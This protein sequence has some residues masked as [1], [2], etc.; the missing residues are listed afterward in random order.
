MAECDHLFFV[1]LLSKIVPI[2]YKYSKFYGNIQLAKEKGGIFMKKLYY[3]Y[4]ILMAIISMLP[5]LSMSIKGILGLFFIV[6]SCIVI[7]RKHAILT[8]TLWI[9]VGYINF[10]I[11]IN[12]DYRNGNISMF[13]GSISYYLIAYFFGG[14]TETIKSKNKE[15]R[16]E[17]ERRKE[18][19]R[20]LNEKL[21]LLQSLMDTIPSPIFFKDLTYKYIGCNRAYIA[22]MGISEDELI[23]KD[24]FDIIDLERANYHH[25]MDEELL[26]KSGK[27]VYELTVQFADGSF[28]DMIF[29]KSVFTD[30]KG[31]PI[32]IVGVMTDITDKKEAGLL[33]QSI[34]EKKQIIDEILENDKMK[35]E[36]FSNISHELR[37]PLNVILGSVQLMELYMNNNQYHES[38]EKVARNIGTMK[39]NCYRLLR[40]VNNLI[41]ISKIDAEAF[42]LHLKNCNIIN[43]I[44]EITLS[45]SDYI[46]NK[47]LRLAF[48]ADIDEIIMACDDEKIERILLNLLSNSIKFTPEGGKISVSTYVNKE[49]LCIKVEDNGSGIPQEKQN[50]VFQRF[51]QIDKMFTRLHE[52]SGIGLNLVKSL[53][54]MHGG[55]ITFQSREG[56]GTSFVIMLPIK[57]VEEKSHLHNTKLKQTHI[58]RIHVEFS[59]IYSMIS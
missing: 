40:L 16:D 21:T 56:A 44:K 18:V 24:V 43:V 46:E 39:Q 49:S 26:E 41:D 51:C 14:F 8:A 2:L 48:Y 42:E 28:R 17:I 6:L 31:E 23:G 3:P 7:S 38:K 54:E 15:L 1:N 13:L 19:E 22:S 52:G 4:Y 10:F 35:T 33:K 11:G 50:L 29:N 57:L 45:V 5:F 47:G 36:F 25:K 34:V 59:D 20:E 30:D 55:T 53:V 58:E 32:G 12:V 9:V 27:Q 37:T